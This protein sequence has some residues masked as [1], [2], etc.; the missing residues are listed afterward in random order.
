MRNWLIVIFIV[1]SIL[2]SGQQCPLL[3]NPVNGAIEVPVNTTITWPKVEGIVG[4]LISLGTTP[5][6]TD[7]LNRRSAGL[8]NSFTPPVGL[9][10]ETII[11]VT[12]EMFLPGQ[13]IIICPGESFSTINV[14]KPPP[15]TRLIEPVDSGT[16]VSVSQNLSWAYAPTATGYRV[17]IGTEAGV[18][19]I[20]NN[21]DVGNV[22][23]YNPPLDFE[24]EEEIFVKIVPYNEN[25]DAVGCLNESFITGIPTFDCDAATD[26][27]TGSIYSLTPE[28][29][30]PDYVSL[31]E[32]EKIKIIQSRD[33]ARGFRWFKLNQDGSETL[34]SNIYEVELDALGRYRYEAFNTTQVLGSTFECS[35]SK[36]FELISAEQPVINNIDVTREV[37][38]LNI[39]VNISGSGNYEFAL[40]DE[41]GNYQDSNN[42]SGIF[43]GEHIVYVRDKDGCGVVSR[44]VERDLSAK[45]F[46]QF[47][48][49]NNDGINDYWQFK[50]PP[51]LDVTLEVIRVYDRYG[52]F[53]AQIDP[54]KRGWNGSSNGQ[55]LPAA[56]YWFR[57]I[58]VSQK[59]VH[60]H[61]SLLR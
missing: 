54:K 16:N 13:Q 21:I 50:P 6:G 8:T 12:I 49:P 18:F 15:C 36:E 30:F 14:T 45:D 61:F 26:P 32:G 24:L 23:S 27:V 51:D 57:A 25:G 47:F 1:N 59:I 34:I 11:Y 31:C 17:N 43:L 40:D 46:P 2:V 5:G 53:L 33:N 3:N 29:N 22:L 10:D 9:P 42:F 19:D 4:Y 60:G 20:A 52:N 38:G 58:S 37:D 44:I 55:E 28:I 35:N 56:D 48:S 7:I 41:N 39:T